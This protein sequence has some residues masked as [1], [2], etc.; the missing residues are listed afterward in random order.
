[1]GTV[2]GKV[3]LVA[4]I[5]AGALATLP[6]IRLV[7]GRCFFEQGCGDREAI[8]LIAVGVGSL[9][10]AAAVGLVVRLAANSVFGARR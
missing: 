5:I 3:G 4:G 1:M 8:G 6:I 7:L 2:G 9:A 10:V